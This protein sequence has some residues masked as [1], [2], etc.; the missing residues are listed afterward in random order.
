V[1]G[2]EIDVLTFQGKVVRQIMPVIP[3]LEEL[4]RVLA[5]RKLGRDALQ[6]VGSVT[7]GGNY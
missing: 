6:E 2:G 5:G 4:L 7:K 3:M 1:K